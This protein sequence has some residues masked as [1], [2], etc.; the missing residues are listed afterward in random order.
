MVFGGHHVPTIIGK[1]KI[2]H[3]VATKCPSN[4]QGAKQRFGG[5]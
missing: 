5:H 3:M 1:N 2:M 4:Q